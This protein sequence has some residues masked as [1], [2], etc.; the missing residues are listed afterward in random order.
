MADKTNAKRLTDSELSVFCTQIAMLLRSGISVTEGLGIMVEDSENTEGRAIL[1]TALD[2]CELGEPLSSGLRASGAFPEYL[3]NM[4]AIG[5]ESGRLD[6]VMD[7]LSSYYERED[8]LHEAVRSAVRYPLVMIV[9]MAVVMGGSDDPRVARFQ[10]GVF[11]AGHRAER[12]LPLHPACRSGAEPVFRPAGCIGCRRGR[13]AAL[14]EQDRRRARISAQIF[15]EPRSGQPQIGGQDRQRPVRQRMSLMLSS[16][17]DTDKS[18]EMVSRLVDSPL[19]RKK[20]AH[21]QELIGEGQNFAD[22]L[23]NAGLFT[24]VYA[25]M[26]TV[27]YKTGSA[28]AVMKNLADR[29]QEEIDT[30]VSRTV[31]LIEPT[32]VAVFSVLVGFILLSVMLP[33]MGIMSS[34][35]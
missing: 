6:E 23:V 30:Q 33:L 31:S 16:G 21:C 11:A 22:A 7:A 20:I 2:H 17:L 24:G 26:V 35:G 12:G 5:E 1:K 8:A 28:D 4:T 34:I 9:M 15:F 14:A 10:R 32:L 18:L 25:R 3:L 27:G 19:V 29:Y 13:C